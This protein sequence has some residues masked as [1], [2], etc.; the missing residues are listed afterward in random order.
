MWLAVRMNGQ[1]DLL[2]ALHQECVRAHDSNRRLGLFG[3]PTG[4]EPG[5]VE[6]AKV[7]RLARFSFLAPD[8]VS[9]ILEGRQP[10]TLQTR[11][12]LRIAA[13]PAC[14]SEQRRMLGFR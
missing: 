3:D 1:P 7:F 8:I 13:L 6:K 9:A 2:A 5:E 14:W 11:R 4:D 12:L 10:P